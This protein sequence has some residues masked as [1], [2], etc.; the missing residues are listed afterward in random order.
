MN[1][2]HNSQNSR[3]KFI[4]KT[5]L[6]SAMIG[7]LSSFDL[8]AETQVKKVENLGGLHL[9]MTGYDYQRVKPFFDQKVGI[10]DCTFEMVKSGGIGDM[11]TNVFNGPQTFDV[12]EIGI[13]PFI[14]AYVNDEFRDYKLLPIFP[15]RMFRHK[16]IFIHADGPIKR[17]E[18]LKGKR[19]GTPG[20]SSSSLTWIR[21]MLQDE[22]GISPNDV[23]WVIANK[24]SSADVS[25]KRSAQEQVF[26][27]E[28]SI[29]NGT[30]G[31][32]ESDL[33]LSGEVDALF[34]AAQPKEFIM[35]NPKIV[36]L[37]KNSKKSEQEYFLKTGIFPIMHAVAVKS[38]L[39]NNNPWLAKSIFDAYAKAKKMDYQH[40]MKLGWAYDTLP[41]YGQEFEETKSV[42]GKN[43]YSYG[44]ENNR[45]VLET[46]CRYAFEQGLIKGQISFED[47]F[48]KPSSVLSEK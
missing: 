5:A 35:G 31:K 14:I 43:F 16:S 24:D 25:G 40:M 41:W 11:N 17:P 18:D 42:M 1:K 12:T 26:P 22:Y 15:L 4:K 44:Y 33:L 36:R 30:P 6:G 10:K 8:L 46:I 37:F 28:I 20:Y 23:Q 21:G 32:D 45:N 13:L 2:N 39:L 3:R 27:K 38:E 29:R 7:S 47:L 34:H 19:I 9:K 48:F